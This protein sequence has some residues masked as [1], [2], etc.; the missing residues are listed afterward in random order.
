LDQNNKQI[1]F[2]YLREANLSLN[3]I[4][5]NSLDTFNGSLSLSTTTKTLTLQN[6][7]RH[8]DMDVI[9]QIQTFEI[10]MGIGGAILSIPICEG[11][12]LGKH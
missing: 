4:A 8:L 7:L 10:V 12:M 6:I 9:K 3:V 5:T 11:C 1:I 2:H